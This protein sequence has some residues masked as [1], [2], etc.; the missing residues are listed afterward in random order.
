MLYSRDHFVVTDPQQQQSLYLGLALSFLSQLILTESQILHLHVLMEG[1][2]EQPGA[3][4]CWPVM[5]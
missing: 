3:L 2:R 5:V 4:P 1:L